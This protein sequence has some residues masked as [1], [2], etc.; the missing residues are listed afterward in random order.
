MQSLLPDGSGLFE[1]AFEQS[2][3]ERWPA[4]ERGAD[5]IRGA[6]FNPPPSFLPFLVYEYGLGE[7][8]PY[9]PN[10]YTLV[11]DREGV[12]WQRIR[13]TPA[14]VYKGLG[15]LGY[16]ATLEDAWHGRVYWNSTQLRFPDLPSQDFPDLERIEGITRL[17][18]PKRSDLRRG[19]HQYD[20][21]A[22]VADGGRLDNAMLERESGV[23]FTPAGTLWS[24]GRT[25]EV[26]HVLSEAEGMAIG[27][28][29][30]VPEEAG[31][32][33]IEM[34]YP[35]VTATFKWADNPINQRR[36]LMA[37]WFAGR[38]LF[39]TLRDA[40]GEVIGHRRCRAIHPVNAQF[41][42]R[43]SFAGAGYSPA[44]GGRQVY[45]EAMTGFGD[46]AGVEAASIEITVGAEL[47]ADIKPGRLWLQ[48][49]ELVGGSP[50]AVTP[51][52]IPLRAT[53]R[54]QLKFLVRF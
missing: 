40:A 44:A 4:L 18:L 41:G 51:V 49:D 1:K 26:E 32:K 22:L 15:W 2:W 16:T 14:S 33:W 42:G 35:W 38:R 48:P 7:L 29:I 5:A 3:A 19:V 6:K 24:F 36:A 20:G 13:G 11:V 47:A 8:T 37:A 27:N 23:A 30:A 45:I 10:H 54:E 52:S 53:V 25:T 39:V 21:T 28:W 43:Y 46:A 9:V 31:L 12:D 50:I 17:S 34:T